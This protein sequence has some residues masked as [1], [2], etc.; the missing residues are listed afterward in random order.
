[1]AT[2][3]LFTQSLRPS[4]SAKPTGN[5]PKGIPEAKQTT[6]MTALSGCKLTIST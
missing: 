5:I 2:R 3:E 6:D 4:E 1:M